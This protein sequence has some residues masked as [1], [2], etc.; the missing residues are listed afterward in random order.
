MTQSVF[1]RAGKKLTVK[2][3]SD[4]V[5]RV[6]ISP[7]KEMG[8][9]AE[10]M[11]GVVSLGQGTPSFRTPAHIGAFVAQK[12]AEGAVDKYIMGPG[13]PDLRH[14]IADKLGRVNRIDANPDTELIVTVGAN[15]ALCMAMLA[16]VNEGEEVL[17]TSPNYSPHLEQA[18][19]AGGNVK[20]VP[21]VE[22][23]GWRL[24]VEAFAQA[25]SR[26]TKLV[27]LNTPLNPTGS[28]L[29][30]RDLR[31][32]AEVVLQTDAFVLTD[33]TYED[34][35]FGKERHFSL[36]SIPAMR[37]R[38]LSVFSFSKSY[39][40]TGWR[41]GYVHAEE[42]LINQLLK[43]HDALCICAPLT[44]Q[45]AALA[46]LTGPQDCVS[47]FRGEIAQ[48]AR[49]VEKR[50]AELPRFSSQPLAGAYYAFPRVAGLRDSVGYCLELLHGAK[51][52]T[53]PGSAFGP[54]GEGHI[55]LSYC[56]EENVIDQ[57]FD[58]IQQFEKKQGHGQPLHG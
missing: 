26:H 37:P 43:L 5:N 1:Q 55:R 27:V 21:L 19:V 31:A 4:R 23:E 18:G 10:S 6:K 16:L 52:V 57:A 45:Y 9:L 42:G 56:M 13:L 48:R 17:M 54:T 20:F 35:V 50:M 33:E 58:R 47:H 38:T 2:G 46:A 53:V 41:C 22:E 44:A 40:M 28:V 49:L 36:A 11:Q 14:A 8:L 32:L 25:I 29:P 12:I 24:D 30:E 34:F 51:V 3:T 39:A 7:I 15:Q